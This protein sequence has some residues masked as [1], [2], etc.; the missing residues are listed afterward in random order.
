MN[1]IS[2][3]EGEVRPPRDPGSGNRRQIGPVGIPRIGRILTADVVPVPVAVEIAIEAEGLPIGQQYCQTGMWQR[4]SIA[5]AGAGT[6]R[7]AAARVT[8]ASNVALI[9]LNPFASSSFR[10]SI[11]VPGRGQGALCGRRRGRGGRM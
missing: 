7:P 10:F 11:V 9:L 1:G 6:N 3:E 4:M 5:C 2:G 8:E